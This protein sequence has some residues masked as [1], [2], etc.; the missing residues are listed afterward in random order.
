MSRPPGRAGMTLMRRFLQFAGLPLHGKIRPEPDP[1]HVLWEPLLISPKEPFVGSS[2]SAS[3][4]LAVDRQLSAFMVDG[5]NS[6]GRT[7]IADRSR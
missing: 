7:G 2:G 5:A 4:K 6:P 3:A 1:H